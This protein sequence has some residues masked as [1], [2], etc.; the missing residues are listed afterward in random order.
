MAVNTPGT[1]RR[2]LI[3]GGFALA[4]A[5][6]TQSQILH[7]PAS[8]VSF[9]VRRNGHKIGHHQVQFSGNET[10]FITTISATMSVSFGPVTVWRYQH[11]VVET[12]RGGQLEAFQSR[13]MTNGKQEQ[14]IAVRTPAGFRVETPSR[15]KVFPADVLP[16]THWNMHGLQNPLFNPQ[17]GAAL[18]ER[19]SRQDGQVVHLANAKSLSAIRYSLTG[20]ANITNWYDAAG[21][22]A[23]LQARAQDGSNVD[24]R[25]LS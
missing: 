24:Y 17:S 21:N 25:R 2:T 22:W 8:N 5:S 15:A 11:D 18:H 9:E 12:W 10:D 4:Y 13:S 7:R 20:D 16:L 3:A 1:T 6:N 14:V 19:V 23:A